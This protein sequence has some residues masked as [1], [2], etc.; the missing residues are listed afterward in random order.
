MLYAIAENGYVFLTVIH[1]NGTI[2]KKMDRTYGP[3]IV[4]VESALRPAT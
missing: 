3:N 4:A 1:D 2:Q